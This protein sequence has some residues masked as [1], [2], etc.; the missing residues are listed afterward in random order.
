MIHTPKETDSDMRP[1]SHGQSEYHLNRCP[2]ILQTSNELRLQ[3]FFITNYIRQQRDFSRLFNISTDRTS[4]HL[5]TTYSMFQTQVSLPFFALP[6]PLLHSFPPLTPSFFSVS[7]LFSFTSLLPPPTL[8][9]HPLYISPTR[10]FH[11]MPQWPNM[12]EIL[13][14]VKRG[15]QKE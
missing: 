13:H 9:H 10:G 11:W 14:F 8:T 4:F 3:Q 1:I 2:I 7:F 5:K 6:S 12:T 15:K